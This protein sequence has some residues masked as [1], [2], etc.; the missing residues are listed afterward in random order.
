[1]NKVWSWTKEYGWALFQGGAMSALFAC[2][3]HHWRWWAFIIP[4]ILLVTLTKHISWK[5]GWDAGV[6]HS[7]A[8]IQDNIRRMQRQMDRE[9]DESMEQIEETLEAVD[10]EEAGR[11][12]VVD[13]DSAIEDL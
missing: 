3:V 11:I 8:Q 1:M 9:H 2:Q 13:I 6:E 4:M 7:M 10:R 5:K 12:R